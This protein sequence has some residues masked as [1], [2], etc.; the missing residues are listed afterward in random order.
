MNIILTII[1]CLTFLAGVIHFVLYYKFKEVKE[2]LYFTIYC[3]ANLFYCI[4]CFFV[5]NTKDMLL[6]SVFLRIQ[7]SILVIVLVT[8]YILVKNI[9]R[10]F[11]YIKNWG[12][13]FSYY[14]FITI[15]SRKVL[16][17]VIFF[18]KISVLNSE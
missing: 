13:Y 1:T 4:I 11:N 10:R 12:L 9:I 17:V 8:I 2:N 3:F 15:Y 16:I 18:N 6:W 14:S 7:Y 5:Y